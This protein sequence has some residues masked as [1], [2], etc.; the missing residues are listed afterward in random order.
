[1]SGNFTA[2]QHSQNALIT[3]DLAGAAST[4]VAAQTVSKATAT[5]TTTLRGS[6][7]AVPVTAGAGRVGVGMVGGV[8]VVLMAL[9]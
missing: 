3:S 4:T 2:A 9:I 1:M 6:G 8:V 5:T 7:T